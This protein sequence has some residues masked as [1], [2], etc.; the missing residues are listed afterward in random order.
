MHVDNVILEVDRLSKNYGVVQA[1]DDV[2]FS[3]RRGEVHALLGE[4]GAGK[5]TLIKIISGEVL[6]AA[7]RIL[8]DGE[9]VRHYD[10]RY[11]MER[12]IA[13]VHQELSI[14]ENVTVAE[15]IFPGM[16]FRKKSGLI[17]RRKMNDQATERIKMF[18]MAI[19]ATQR[20]DELTL[21]QCQMVE[22]LRCLGVG[23]HIILLDEPTSGLN[24]EET[25]KL[26]KII[27]RLKE[28]GITVVYIS[29]RINEIMS[30]SDRI[31]VLRDGRYIQT[32]DKTP[33][34][35]AME[36][37]K[38]MVGRDLSNT[39]YALRNDDSCITDEIV[40]EARDLIKNNS[41]QDI[42]FSLRKGEILGFFGLEGSG[43]NSLSRIIYGLE[44]IDR[45][46]IFVRGKKIKRITP[47]G[48][49]DN[50]IMYLNNNRKNA[51][52]F[53]DMPVADN[54]SF[55]VLSDTKKGIFLDISKVIAISSRFINEFKIVIQSLWHPP[56]K[57]SGGNQQKLMFSMCLTKAPDILILNEPTR[58]VDVGAKY[59]IHKF[60]LDLVQKG[61][62]IIIF[63]SEMPEIMSLAN[64]IFVMHENQIC[65]EIAKEDFSEQNIILAASGAM[66]AN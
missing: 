1:L 54:I 42:S 40:F 33:E 28:Q 24:I 22:I 31:T 2:S 12:G 3:I 60:M 27:R 58:G 50:H 59:E 26:M 17:D 29:H 32:F 65:A 64:R 41:I 45:G 15:N 51:G 55:P 13:M 16:E 63:S 10:P 35:T 53:L 30:I 38:T 11:A 23:Q 34:L 46:E 21:A 66:L 57:L 4:N 61:V 62:S 18:G 36:L 48:M 14:F 49:V 43:T 44:G 39:L 8:I 47:P 9:P 37:V 56:K 25:D 20:M 7:G 52:L 6:P 5:S 19:K